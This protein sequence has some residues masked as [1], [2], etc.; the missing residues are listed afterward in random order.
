MESQIDDLARQVIPAELLFSFLALDANAKRIGL[1]VCAVIAG[2][3]SVIAEL[4]R[5]EADAIGATV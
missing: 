5:I 2:A 4:D 3:T 1:R